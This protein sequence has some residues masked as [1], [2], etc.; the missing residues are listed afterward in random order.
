MT[1]LRRPAE[2]HEPRGAAPSVDRFAGRTTF[3]V[4]A[5]DTNLTKRELDLMSVL[6]SHPGLTIAELRDRLPDQLAPQTVHTML[7]LLEAKGCV[8]RESAARAS[9]FHPTITPESEGDGLLKRLVNKVFRGS[10]S[11]LVVR[12]LADESLSVSELREMESAIRDRLREL[13]R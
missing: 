13:D 1:A 6:W 12:L 2:A 7:R 11:Q 4:M 10:R 3:L 8:R 9:T 5:D